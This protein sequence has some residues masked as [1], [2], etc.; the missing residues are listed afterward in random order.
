MSPGFDQRIADWLED[1]PDDAPDIVLATVLAAFPS[2]P[3]RRAI[4]AP[5]RFRPMTLPARL[6]AA[7]IAIAV[8]AAGGF[9]ILRPSGPSVSSSPSAPPTGSPSPSTTAALS[10]APSASL[11]WST[12]PG[13]LLLEHYGNPLDLS[14]PTGNSAG[15]ICGSW[16][17]R[18]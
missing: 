11:D 5:W 8:V 10:A 1:D 9:L 13:R 15:T 16:T 14:H 4:R 2:I 12:L 7:V 17:R 18:T 6:V 3:Q